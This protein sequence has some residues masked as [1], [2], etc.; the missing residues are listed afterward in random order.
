MIL[1]AILVT[2]FITLSGQSVP[3]EAIDTRF[4][5]TEFPSFEKCMEVKREVE[6]IVYQRHDALIAKGHQAVHLMCIEAG[7]NS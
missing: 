6:G 3:G 1:K 2:T 5:P 4:K 7:E